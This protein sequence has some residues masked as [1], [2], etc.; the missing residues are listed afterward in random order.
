MPGRC[1][2][3]IM[4]KKKTP[5]KTAGARVVWCAPHALLD[6]M[7]PYRTG[8]VLP[9]KLGEYIIKAVEFVD[10]R[11]YRVEHGDTDL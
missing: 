7:T 10:G 11:D 9:D 2:R 3:E 6:V 8:D 1:A 4:A 5:K